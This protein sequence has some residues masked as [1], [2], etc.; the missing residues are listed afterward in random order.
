MNDVPDQAVSVQVSGQ[1]TCSLSLP[2]LPAI[3]DLVVAM[4]SAWNNSNEA[5][6]PHGAMTDNQGVHDYLLIQEVDVVGSNVHMSMFFTIVD[7]ASGTFTVTIDP[8]PTT[9]DISLHL[10]TWPGADGSNPLV[11]SAQAA[12]TTGTAIATAAINGENGG[13]A[14]GCMSS[15]ITDPTYTQG[16]GF[17]MWLQTTDNTGGQELSSEAK[18]CFSTTTY[19]VNA[20]GSLVASGSS[21]IIIGATFRASSVAPQSQVITPSYKK[22]P[23]V[24]MR[25]RVRV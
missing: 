20:T 23:K 19:V 5:S 2:S 11:A 15:T 25:S 1:N 14:V 9:S 10:L 16:S 13:I 22:F 4:A 12:V 17:T 8:T 6:M 21:Y 7:S 18:G 3:G 24:Q